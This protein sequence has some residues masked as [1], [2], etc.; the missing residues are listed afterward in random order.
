MS[1]PRLAAATSVAAALC[2]LASSAAAG[3]VDRPAPPPAPRGCAGLRDAGAQPVR[4][5][6][7]APQR[8]PGCFFFSGPFQL[9]RDDHL[10]SE[11]ELTRT[12]PSARLAFGGAVFT[13]TVETGR[14]RLRRRS[15]H[16]F[17]GRWVVEET[18]E[19]RLGP[20]RRGGEACAGIVAEYRYRE[21]PEGRSCTESCTIVAPLEITGR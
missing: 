17:S 3:P 18:I 9:G 1:R 12:G 7:S 4:V 20:V 21:C 14:V 16:D 15:T 11:A 13:G 5:A 2:L 19:G 6:W 8:T 10:G